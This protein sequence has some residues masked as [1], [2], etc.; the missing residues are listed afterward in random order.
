MK[1]TLRSAL[2]SCVI[3]FPAAAHVTGE[4]DQP[5]IVVNDCTAMAG[6]YDAG[7]KR[8]VSITVV[9]AK[10]IFTPAG[11]D[12]VAGECVAPRVANASFYPQAKT[13]F[14]ASFGN[15]LAVDGCCTLHLKDDKLIFDNSKMVW[16]RR[17]R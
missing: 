2:V 8:V 15:E 12:P 6:T 5:R 3:A 13:K 17:P 9:D 4:V 1:R 16:K 11:G 10:V 7:A 14:D